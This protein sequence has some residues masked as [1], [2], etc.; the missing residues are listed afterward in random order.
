VT[1]LARVFCT[2]CN[3][4]TLYLRPMESR[5]FWWLV[6]TLC[7]HSSVKGGENDNKTTN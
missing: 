1:V 4:A 3:L 6:S 7:S 2:R 5:D